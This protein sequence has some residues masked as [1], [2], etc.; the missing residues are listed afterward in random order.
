MLTY[1]RNETFNNIEPLGD[2]LVSLVRYMRAVVYGSEGVLIPSPSC[3][4]LAS[5]S[6]TRTTR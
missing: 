3:T 6:N 5:V 2:S 4:S 1:T